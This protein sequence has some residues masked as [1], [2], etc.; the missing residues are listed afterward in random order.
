MKNLK[1]I[2]ALVLA[3]LLIGVVILTLV[4]AF[5]ATPE[6]GALFNASMFSMVAL[7]I[8]L[9]AVILVYRLVKDR[10]NDANNSDN[11]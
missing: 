8:F 10:N 1:R 3:L 11:N 7:P 5:F 2:G 9:F 6:S 4:S